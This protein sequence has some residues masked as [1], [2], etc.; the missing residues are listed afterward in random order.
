MN[1]TVMAKLCLVVT[2]YLG[3]LYEAIRGCVVGP[4]SIPQ[5]GSGEGQEEQEVEEQEQQQEESKL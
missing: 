3:I 1:S 2:K 4:S 5:Q